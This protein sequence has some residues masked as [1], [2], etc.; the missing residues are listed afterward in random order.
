MSKKAAIIMNDYVKTDVYRI[1]GKY[2]LLLF[3]KLFLRNKSFRQIFY[4]RMCNSKIKYLFII[5]FHI[6]SKK[7]SIELPISTVIGK[8][9]RMIHP[10]NITFNSKARIGDNLTI[11]KGATIG[12]VHNADGTVSAPIIGNNC[13]IGLNAA[14][15]GGVNIGDDVLIAANSFVNFDVPSHSVVIGN[16]GVIHKKE[17]ATMNYIENQIKR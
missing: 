12:N 4:Y 1:T 17:N 3:F 16:P 10:Y 6:I 13:Y 7:S 5:P 9:L 14:V 11:L 2:S 15:V 8:G